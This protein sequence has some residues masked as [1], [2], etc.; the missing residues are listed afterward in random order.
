M[1]NTFELISSQNISL[2]PIDLSRE[3]VNVLHISKAFLRFY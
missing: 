2:N 3:T 1:E